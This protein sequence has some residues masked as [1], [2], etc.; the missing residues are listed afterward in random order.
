M[1]GGQFFLVKQ[2][3]YIIIK[4]S[5]YVSKEISFF[6]RAKKGERSK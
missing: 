4:L 3:N 1:W 6:V 5:N 2:R